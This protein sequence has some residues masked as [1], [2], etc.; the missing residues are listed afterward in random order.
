[1]SPKF[2]IRK[3]TRTDSKSFL[4]LLTVFAKWEHFKTPDAKAR[5]RIIEDI[6]E[7]K[8]ANLLVAMA[9]KKLLGYALYFYTYSSFSALP[10]LYLE[11]LFVLEETRQR[12]LG[13]ALF[14]RCL[15]EARNQ[16]CG[17][18]EWAVLTWNRNAIDFYEKQGAKK[19][20]VFV[21]Y[22]KLDSSQAKS[23]SSLQT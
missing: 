15:Q 7:K 11:D 2:T 14:K 8:L 5:K 6:F 9:G 13:K 21:Y 22:I 1:M 16:G 12:G 3:A 19:D 23:V 18:M 20:D 10:T 17:K 4:T